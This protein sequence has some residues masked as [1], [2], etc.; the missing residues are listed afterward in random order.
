M[1]CALAEPGRKFLRAGLMA[2]ECHTETTFRAAEQARDVLS[3][4]P[5][6]APSGEDQDTP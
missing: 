6:P 4:K 5:G 1:E 2:V 3:A